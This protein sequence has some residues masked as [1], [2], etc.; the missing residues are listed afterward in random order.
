MTTATR[1]TTP[2]TAPTTTASV[3]E[4]DFWLFG[5]DVVSSVLATVGHGVGHVVVGGGCVL[6]F[7]RIRSTSSSSRLDL[8]TVF[9]SS[10]DLNYK[11]NGR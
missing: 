3:E 6:H 4:L 8:Q 11:Y 9:V 1:T 2:T 7:V 5:C 10:V